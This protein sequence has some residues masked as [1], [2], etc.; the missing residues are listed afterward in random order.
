MSLDM[1]KAVVRRAV[2]W[3]DALEPEVL[4]DVL[5]PEFIHNRDQERST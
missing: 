5:S 3:F 2:E 1:N 4:E